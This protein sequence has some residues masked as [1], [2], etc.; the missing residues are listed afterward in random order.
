MDFTAEQIAG[1]LNGKVEGNPAAK[2][3]DVSKI[4]EGRPGTLAFLAN[5]KYEKYIYDTEA[6]IVLVNNL[7]LKKM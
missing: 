6:T 3:N 2:V 5:P 1:F 7:V 4:E